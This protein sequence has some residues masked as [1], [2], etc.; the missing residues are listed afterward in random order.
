MLTA[1]A[2]EIADHD[3]ERLLAMQR[4]DLAAHRIGPVAAHGQ[5]K[6]REE[7][8]CELQPK[9]RRGSIGRG[10]WNRIGFSAIFRAAFDTS[11]LLGQIER[12]VVNLV[13]AM[14]A[15]Q[16]FQRADLAALG[17]RMQEI[18]LDPQDFH[19]PE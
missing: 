4:V 9:S 10:V 7:S 14:Q 5:W 8:R 3:I 12:D 6:R 2:Q 18:R 19:K 16:D 1:G 13:P 15:L 17:G 11:R